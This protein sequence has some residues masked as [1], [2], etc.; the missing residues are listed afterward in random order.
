MG[1][2]RD[3]ETIFVE[4]DAAGEEHRRNDRV[5]VAPPIENTS[6]KDAPQR[7][8][9]RSRLRGTASRADDQSPCRAYSRRVVCSPPICTQWLSVEQ[10][11]SLLLSLID[12]IP[13]MLTFYRPDTR[14]LRLNREFE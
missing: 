13:V 4:D 2:S 12:R 11:S 5:L 6:F 8:R 14:V 10:G 7:T 1:L 3:C 9:N